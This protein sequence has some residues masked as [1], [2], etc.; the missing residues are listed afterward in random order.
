MSDQL[1]GYEETAKVLGL[2]DAETKTAPDSSYW[3]H[4]DGD[5]LAAAIIDRA[6]RF[7]E[8]QSA[9]GLLKGWR[10]KLHYYFNEYRSNPE[11]PHLS[12][13]ERWG[14]QGEYSFVS[15]NHLRSLLKTVLSAIQQSPPNFQPVAVNS[16]ADSLEEASLY[17]GVLDYYR[18]DLRLDQKIARAVEMALVID[19]GFIL[20]EWDSFASDGDAPAGEAIWKGAPAVSVLSPWDVTYDVTKSDWAS[21]DWVICRCWV[22]RE[23]VKAQFPELAS[24]I[25]SARNRAAVTQSGDELEGGS[26]YEMQSFPEISNDIQVYK[27]FHRAQP[28]MPGGRF[29][30][31]LENGKMLFESPVGLMYP[32]L[33]VERMVADEQVDILLGYSPINELLGPQE[34]VN[35][36]VSAI[37]TNAGNYGNQYI[38]CQA[39]TELNPRTLADG[40]KVIEYPPQGHPP[41]GLNLTAIPEVLFKHLSDLMSYMQ[42]VPGVSS[43]SRG[44]A[45]GANSTGSAMLFLSSQTSQNQSQFSENY[46]Q[47]AA[48]TMTSLLHVLRVFGRT[49]KTI[50]IMGKTVASKTIVL[51]DA[52]KNFDEIVVQMTNPV[53]N[54]PQGKLSFAQ[55]L[56]QWGNATPEQ[57]L[58]VATSGNLGPAVNPS[59]ELQYELESENEWL[60]AGDQVLVNALDNH[61]QHIAMHT[62]LF[63]TPWMRK[64]SLA[65]KLNIMNAP[66][67]MQNV[68]QHIQEHMQYLQQNQAGSVA[69]TAGQQPGQPVQQPS[70]ALG[71]MPAASPD[72]GINNPAQ[73]QQSAKLP[74]QPSAPGMPQ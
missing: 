46:E 3:A 59:Q 36:L 41:V 54:T 20:T 19:Q 51:A 22:D 10:L 60:L 34:N 6:K 23:K 12:I 7:R 31:A 64:P 24:D 67:L 69:A 42:Q 5:E 62:R 61:E 73:A 17:Q 71:H 53:L 66:Q 74:N 39:G 43:A 2:N 29:V 55:Q 21:L 58:Q 56:L 18:R 27:L 32:R 13:M 47:F 57:A 72:V 30:M 40:Q 14:A 68:Q 37:S 1:S 50:Q 44:Q 15:I 28:W 70:P 33:P 8:W 25:E 9:N 38:A 16:D 52:L 26:R 48:N 49:E 63:A 45:P 4:L 11:I 35:S 65:Q